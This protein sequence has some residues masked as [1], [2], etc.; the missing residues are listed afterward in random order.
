V[1]VAVAILVSW[2]RKSLMKWGATAEEA[3]LAL[4][5]DSVLPV[6]NASATRAVLINVDRE[7]V[8]P[9]VVQ[10]GQG[11]GG[12]YSY[13]LI[14]NLIGCDIHSAEHVVADWQTLTVGDVIH[15][16]PE[17]AL[18][19]ALVEPGRSLVLRG[20][21]PM[22]N[23][24]PPYDFTWAFVLRCAPNG[25]IRLVVRERYQYLRWWSAFLVEPVQVV[26]FVMSQKMLRGIRERAERPT[27][28]RHLMRC[29]LL[30]PGRCPRRWW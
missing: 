23:A 27:G 11:R 21:V 3:H 1:L 13:D 30:L 9:W 16:H 20:A 25:A 15:L 26:S 12:F 18:T 22:G 2:L 14:E 19:V 24:P 28:R 17:V 4:P 29:V 10:L 6:A 8:W 7:A 5:G